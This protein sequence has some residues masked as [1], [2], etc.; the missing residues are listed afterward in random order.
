M[1]GQKLHLI[2]TEILCMSQNNAKIKATTYGWEN[3]G[4]AV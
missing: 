4:C 3:L 2:S 1:K